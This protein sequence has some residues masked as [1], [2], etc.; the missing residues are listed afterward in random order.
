MDSEYVRQGITQWIHGWKK[1]GWVTKTGQPVKNRE[2]WKELD[3]VNR[4]EVSFAYTAGH[5][6]DPDNE[7][8]DRIASDFAKGKDVDLTCGGQDDRPFAPLP[9]EA[10][11]RPG[12]RTKASSAKPSGKPFYLSYVD[13]ELK[14]HETWAECEGR[15]KGVS[16]ARFKKV[17]SP[18]EARE[19]LV[20]WGLSEDAI[21]NL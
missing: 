6:G 3:R 4:K 14:R 9:P 10:G 5:A 18:A 19:F 16:G 12:S 17:K 2:L 7:R 21:E 15:V 1:R 13:C 11:R 20:K 8:V